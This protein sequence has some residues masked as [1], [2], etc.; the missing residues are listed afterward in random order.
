[1]AKRQIGKCEAIYRAI[2]SFHL[3][4]S[5]IACVFV[6]SGYPENQ[7]T[8]LRKIKPKEKEK[9]KIT[10][11]S[12]RIDDSDNESGNDSDGDFQEDRMETTDDTKDVI[13]IPGRKGIYQETEKIHDKYANRPDGIKD[14]TLSQF[15]TSYSKCNKKP[16]NIKFN[17]SDVTEERGDILDHLTEEPLPKYLR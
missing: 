13:R 17:E 12:G 2:P 9:I 4:G 15:A 6:Q 14:L 10:D 5:N 8:Y 7:S 16:K 1:M 11:I 3:Q